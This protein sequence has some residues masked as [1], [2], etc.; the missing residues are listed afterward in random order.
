MTTQSNF[1]FTIKFQALCPDFQIMTKLIIFQQQEGRKFVPF[2]SDA[3]FIHFT[4]KQCSKMIGWSRH[5]IKVPRS[6]GLWIINEADLQSFDLFKYCILLPVFKAEQMFE[7]PG[8]WRVSP[9]KPG[10]SSMAWDN[11][12]L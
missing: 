4:T 7:L 10:P 6:Y 1:G 5:P 8:D 9:C 3:G 2:H 12:V 11:L